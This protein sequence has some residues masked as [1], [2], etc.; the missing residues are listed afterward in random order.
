M[1]HVNGNASDDWKKKKKKKKIKIG[2]TKICKCGQKVF[3]CVIFSN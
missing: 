3:P 1:P 2:K